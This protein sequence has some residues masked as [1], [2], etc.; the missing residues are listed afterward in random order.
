MLLNAKIGTMYK[1]TSHGQYLATDNLM[2]SLISSIAKG[3]Y[4]ILI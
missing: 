1:C 4:E 3:K 2:H